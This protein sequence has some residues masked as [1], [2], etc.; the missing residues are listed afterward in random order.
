MS[1]LYFDQL[2]VAA[3]KVHVVDFNQLLGAAHYFPFFLSFY[4]FY[5]ENMLRVYFD[6]PL[7]CS[8]PKGWSKYATNMKD[9][10]FYSQIFCD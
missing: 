5:V 4:D 9:L 8:A 1:A 6:K 7:E 2:L 3:R 10:K